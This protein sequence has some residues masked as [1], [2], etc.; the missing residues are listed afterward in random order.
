MSLTQL[1]ALGNRSR[2]HSFAPVTQLVR[3]DCPSCAIPYS[4]QQ[5]HHG[6]WGYHVAAA[7]R[8]QPRD[9]DTIGLGAGLSLA[10]WPCPLI[11]GVGVGVWL[12]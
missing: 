3:E 9:T 8:G 1:P 7:A 11:G 10:G 2:V 4:R 6:G 5:Y 12:V